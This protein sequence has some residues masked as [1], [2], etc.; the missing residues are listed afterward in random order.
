VKT[1]VSILA[2]SVI[3]ISAPGQG[4][5]NFVT[6][7]LG[8]DARVHDW[9]GSV[10]G[11]TNKLYGLPAGINGTNFF[12]QLWAAP[13]LNAS[14]ND[15][16]P[17]NNFDNTM[18]NP[19]V[20]IRNNVNAGWV[21]Q[22]GT[23]SLGVVFNGGQLATTVSIPGVTGGGPATVQLRVWYN[24][25]STITSWAAALA[26][27]CRVGWSP[28]LNLLSTGDPLGL[29]PTNPVSLTGLRGFY[30]CVPEPSSL[31]LVGLAAGMMALRRHRSFEAGPKI[32]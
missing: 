32:S 16:Q 18:V 12:A 1:L 13:G 14:L 23:T 30:L 29:P 10:I 4:T 3:A 5:V 6:S 7:N 2:F 21:Q 20:N 26:S 11:D 24:A 25:N 15:L 8:P 9:D 22:T 27:T 19:L 31:A 28:T 17:V